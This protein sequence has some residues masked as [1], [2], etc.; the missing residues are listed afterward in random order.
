MSATAPITRLVKRN[1]QWSGRQV[2]TTHAV[3]L[4]Q[5]FQFIAFTDV[6]VQAP[7]AIKAIHTDPDQ[8]GCGAYSSESGV[9]TIF[10]DRYVVFANRD[11][12][13]PGFVIHAIRSMLDSAVQHLRS[14]DG[15]VDPAFWGSCKV[16]SVGVDCTPAHDESVEVA[17]QRCG[18]EQ[19][20]HEAICAS[21]IR[22]APLRGH[23]LQSEI[24]VSDHARAF[25][26]EPFVATHCSDRFSLEHDQCDTL[27]C[28]LHD[29]GCAICHAHLD[30]PGPVLRAL[31]QYYGWQDVVLSFGEQIAEDDSW[32]SPY[33][34]ITHRGC[35]HA[36]STIVKCVLGNDCIFICAIEHP[37]Q[38]GDDARI[39]YLC[40]ILGWQSGN[41]SKTCVI[42]RVRPGS[43]SVPASAVVELLDALS[44]RPPILALEWCVDRASQAVSLRHRGI[45]IVLHHEDE[46]DVVHA[47][48]PQWI[49]THLVYAHVQDALCEAAFNMTFSWCQHLGDQPFCGSVV[50]TKI[51]LW[52]GHVFTGFLPREMRLSE[53]YGVLS[54]L[55]SHM[56]ASFV[57][58]DQIRLVSAGRTRRGDC[59]IGDCA[60]CSEEAVIH[61][62]LALHGGSNEPLSH[63]R[64]HWSVTMPR[65]PN[66]PILVLRVHIEPRGGFFFPDEVELPPGIALE[67]LDDIRSTSVV[68]VN[69]LQPTQDIT[70]QWRSAP[71]DGALGMLWTGFTLFE[72][73]MPP[74][75]E[76][77]HN[78]IIVAD[79]SR[80]WESE[81]SDD[82][83]Q[84][85]PDARSVGSSGSGHLSVDFFDDDQL[86][87]RITPTSVNS[88]PDCHPRHCKCRCILARTL[89]EESTSH[90]CCFGCMPRSG[91]GG[92]PVEPPCKF[93][94]RDTTYGPLHS[95]VSTLQSVV[96]VSHDCC[97]SIVQDRLIEAACSM[98][99]CK[100]GSHGGSLFR[101]KVKL[102]HGV[103]FSGLVSD[104]LRFGDIEMIFHLVHQFAPTPFGEGL[105]EIRLISGGRRGL[106][107]TSVC[108][109]PGHG[110]RHDR[111][112]HGILK[113]HGGGKAPEPSPIQRAAVVITSLGA[114]H[115]QASS[116]LQQIDHLLG[117]S[118]I[119]KLALE[120]ATNKQL[121]I[122]HGMS[123]AA[124]VPL[125]VGVTPV[126]GAP[127]NQ[128]RTIAC[129]SQFR[130]KPGL[131]VGADGK[132]LEILTSVSANSPPGVVL[133]DP[134]DAAPWILA[135]KVVTH[136][137]VL[138][139]LGTC[140]DTNCP[141]VHLAA[142]SGDDPVVL[143]VCIHQAGGS[144][145][146]RAEK[147]KDLKL[148]P[149]CVLSFSVF[150]DEWATQEWENI[151]QHPIRIMMDQFESINLL[152]APWSRQWGLQGRKADV[153]NAERF[154]FVARIDQSEVV[155]VFQQS[156]L[157]KVYVSPLRSGPDKPSI[158][159]Q[160][161]WI[162]ESHS[163]A[164]QQTRLLVEQHGL[165][166]SY[167]RGFGVRVKAS[168][169]A[170]IFARIDLNGGSLMFRV[171][172]IPASLSVQALR[173]WLV[174]CKWKAA[175]VRQQG[176]SWLISSDTAPPEQF[177]PLGDGHVLVRDITKHS[178]RVQPTVAAGVTTHASG[179]DPLQVNDPWSRPSSVVKTPVPADQAVLI[180]RTNRSSNSRK[181]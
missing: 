77:R 9:V 66:G 59:S 100:E 76:L 21:G 93:T 41:V 72:V 78:P 127:K 18:Q 160:V 14:R 30:Q 11:C 157:N 47:E 94:P 133:I 118:R 63:L 163:T 36:L 144:I 131:F 175:P 55:Q 161:I 74:A 179:L 147:S 58:L 172:P 155:R 38:H 79:P 81:G 154:S 87:D 122:L 177:L 1:G 103:A 124:S 70:D 91:I 84:H 51:K 86:Q 28:V 64:D 35:I 119:S 126:P 65:E 108:A 123:S 83:L 13:S 32:P 180:G 31:C 115:D 68:P 111:T 53:I 20:G 125:P 80:V 90:V 96:N 128:H 60:P 165:I 110:G 113:L 33:S 44:C 132:P 56:S 150:R 174:S 178:A 26:V 176:G 10:G 109:S 142:F 5:V 69:R 48:A 151:K 106:G 130:M 49:P 117:P 135:R 43:V 61:C 67:R 22:L 42:C 107:N 148:P 104:E 57:H 162:G 85:D 173:E 6:D 153:A 52:Y 39:H 102:W 112:V 169:F 75:E 82:D 73:R 181:L 2:F 168:D 141:N 89:P 34:L 99:F 92:F 24:L 62:V 139:V 4:S 29:E 129:A 146:C 97:I 136:E 16:W 149:S 120:T 143:R 171:Q 138:C 101:L 116:F 134:Q 27:V 37:F 95:V 71:R 17:R 114:S 40:A 45:R 7:Q 105:D 140:G 88:C 19:Y 145:A 46:I 158:Q 121:K 25:Q 166:R 23:G 54:S 137:L 15:C 159:F 164:V 50:W 12:D 152:A 3:D 156:G 170:S 8:D 167:R 98:C